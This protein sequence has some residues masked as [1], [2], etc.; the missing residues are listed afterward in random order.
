MDHFSG[1]HYSALSLRNVENIISETTVSRNNRKIL[2]VS[3]ESFTFV[4]CLTRMK[5]NICTKEK[6]NYTLSEM[7]FTYLET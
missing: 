2:I 1:S 7:V 6:H 4:T 3:T 5:L